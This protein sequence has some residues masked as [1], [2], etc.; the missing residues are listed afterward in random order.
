LGAV[1]DGSR[2]VLG[3]SRRWP[4]WRSIGS[5]LAVA[6]AVSVGFVS[7]TP[8]SGDSEEAGAFEM[9]EGCPRLDE[10]VTA[11]YLASHGLDDPVLPGQFADGVEIAAVSCHQSNGDVVGLEIRVIS[12]GDESSRWSDIV[13]S[14]E[15][16]GFDPSDLV[17]SMETDSIAVEDVSAPDAAGSGDASGASYSVRDFV[18][19]PVGEHSVLAVDPGS[20]LAAMVDGTGPSA[21]LDAPTVRLSDLS[22]VVAE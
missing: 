16:K 19:Y 5:V 14:G 9:P 4:R 10:P 11:E 17:R 3:R 18:E 1:V 20:G 22:W 6:G 7:S 15:G 2:R 8:A 12:P 21:A 13:I